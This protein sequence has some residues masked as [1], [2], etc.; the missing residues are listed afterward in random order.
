MTNV[1]NKCAVNKDT[2]RPDDI[3]VLVVGQTGC[4]KS[5]FIN[6]TEVYLRN[7]TME[8]A[9]RDPLNPFIPFSFIESDQDL[10]EKVIT[11][12]EVPASEDPLSFSSVTQECHS[13]TIIINDRRIRFIDTPGI[14][15]TEGVEQDLKNFQVIANYI[16]IV[17]TINAICFVMKP[18]ENRATVQFQYCFNELLKHFDRSIRENIIFVFTFAQTTSFKPG[19]TI[20]LVRKML[21]EHRENYGIDLDCNEDRSFLFDNEAFRYV[22][23]AQSGYGDR[24][25][26]ERCA[27]S[28]RKSRD[29]YIRF[30]KYVA[31]RPQLSTSRTLDLFDAERIIRKLPRPMSNILNLIEEN[32]E[33]GQRFKEELINDPSVTQ[34]GVPQLV[35]TIKQLKYPRT[36]CSSESCCKIV[37]ENDERRTEFKYICHE[38]CYLNGIAQEIIGDEKLD[39]CEAIDT[40]TERCIKCG[41]SWKTH[42]HITYEDGTRT[43]YIYT[44]TEIDKRIRDLRNAL[45][46]IK[47]VNE[48]LSLYLH[49]NS[50]VPINESIIEYLNYSI[51]AAKKKDS[52]Q[53][54]E[55]LQ[56]IESLKE[57][58]VANI[59]RTKELVEN[60][61][62][63]P[64][65][66]E[67]PSADDVFVL[68]KELYDLPFVGIMIRQQVE[69]VGNFE[70]R[71][72]I[73]EEQR[74]IPS[75]S[76][77]NDL[78]KAF[79][80]L[81]I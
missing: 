74:T 36:V 44:L 73:T 65:S 17:E 59:Q 25:T 15:D 35:S 81:D 3:N 48:K 24:E 26:F 50:L 51:R 52:R 32:I 14:G 47:V 70:K 64:D 49:F 37:E 45:E 9:I 6:A 72:D 40:E 66:I 39:S 41:C 21:N 16:S 68:V 54:P 18:N 12:G 75:R 28:W 53:K 69:G 27:T 23:M 78:I 20:R 31:N 30:F 33:F 76:M 4:G 60:Y 79:L 43:E 56:R 61:K 42:L 29:Q 11:F 10:Q 80:G 67:I 2:I 46:T 22:G 77:N 55:H 62:D 13:Y 38:E 8:E 71:K 1:G 57:F 19:G 7:E 63:D 5:T 58:Y 34:R